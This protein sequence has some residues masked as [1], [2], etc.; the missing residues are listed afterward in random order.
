MSLY[1]DYINE[2]L[3][4]EYSSETVI[5]NT[6]DSRIELFKHN[7]SG[8]ELILIKSNNRNDHIYR[9]LRGKK[10][11][12]LPV[13]YDVCSDEDCVIVLE[14]F[15]DGVTLNEKA[16]QSKLSE[17]ETV[18]YILDLCSALS[19]LHSLDIVHRDIK[20]S[21]VIIDGENRAVLIDFSSAR[22]ISLLADN[23]TQ[24]LGTPGYAAPE[25][26]GVYQSLP[27][28]DIYALG[29]LLNELLIG[30]NPIIKTPKGRFGRIIKK[31]T[32][33]QIAE[34]YQTVKELEKDLK[35]AMLGRLKKRD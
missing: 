17:K 21:N 13:I 12:N 18:W 14:S 15:V 20:P 5:K 19:F 30:T 11:R 3:K 8:N 7:N 23:D 28:T 2:N 33:S 26:Y 25:Q 4:I 10:H 32:S 34:R 9:L 22:E 29:V 31:C 35:R 27:A 1:S 6:E 24:H 16:R